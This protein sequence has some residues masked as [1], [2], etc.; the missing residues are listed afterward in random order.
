MDEEQTVLIEAEE[1]DGTRYTVRLTELEFD[2]LSE[3]VENILGL[4]F[5]IKL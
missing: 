5:D 2:A 3:Y 1:E 4:R